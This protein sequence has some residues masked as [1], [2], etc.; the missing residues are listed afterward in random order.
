MKITKT[1]RG[2]TAVVKVARN[3]TKRFSGATR[4]EVSQKIADYLTTQHVAMD[5]PVLLDAIDRYISAREPHRSASGIRGYKSVMRTLSTL[6]GDFCR[7]KLDAVT[8]KAA[9]AVID[10]AQRRGYSPRTI[11]NWIGLI[12]SVLIAENHQPVRVILAQPVTHDRDIPSVGEIKM[13]LC[14]LHGRRLEVPVKL[15]L[16]GLRRGE[17]CALSPSDLDDSGVLHIHRSKVLMDGGG[18]A[19][20]DAP[21][22]DTSNRYIQLSP[23]LADLIRERGVP[24]YHPS[25]LT[26]QFHDFL[27]RYKFPPYRLHDCRHFFASYCHSIGI[28]EAD[29]L[30]GGGWK[31]ANVMKAVY[32]HSMARNRA[33][34]A[35]NNLF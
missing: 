35:I 15:A 31:T 10:D 6:Y 12:N 29:I 30:A 14:L 26:N 3:Q 5:S 11:K 16:L 9:Q 27:V 7:L 34:A 23:D 28:P 17:I 22:T 1:K 24:T 25:T 32:R 19:T 4:A 2:Y 33:S 13:M 8:S 18:C 20:N 21:K